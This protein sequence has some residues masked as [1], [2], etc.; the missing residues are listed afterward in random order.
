MRKAGAPMN[1]RI[2]LYGGA[3]AALGAAGAWHVLDRRPI[4]AGLVTTDAIGDQVQRL[5]KGQLPQ[6]ASTSDMQRLYRYAVEQGDELQYIPCTCGC[7]RFDHKSNRDCYVK[8]FNA[9]GTLTFTS[10]AAT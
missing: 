9:D 7:V 10:H 8:A 6:F 3:V 5:P 2:F 1:R 4:G